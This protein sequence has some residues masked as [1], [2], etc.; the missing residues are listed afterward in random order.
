MRLHRWAIA[1]TTC[2]LA[3]AFAGTPSLAHS[4]D[5]R[6]TLTV[7]KKVVPT[8]DPGKF[9]LRIDGVVHAHNVGNAG[10]TGQVTVV[11]GAHTVSETA[12]TATNL[13]NYVT[14][15]GGD[16]NSAGN[17]T[18]AVGNNKTCI[19]T[20]SRLG[21]LTVVKKVEPPT[22]AGKFNLLIDGHV[23]ADRVGNG[24]TTGAVTV[25]PGAHTVSESAGNGATNLFNYITTYSGDCNATGHV[26]V[27]MG[28]DKLC[29]ITNK[30]RGWT[31]KASMPTAREYFGLGVINN[32]IYVVGGQGD[33]YSALEVY[34]PFTD[35]WVTKASMPTAR[36]GLAVG[37]INGIL[38][39]V[40]GNAPVGVGG[41]H[42]LSTV[43][44]YDPATNTWSTKAPMPTPRDGLAVAV[45]NGILYAIGGD[46]S[47]FGAALNKVEAYDPVTNTWTTKTPL[48]IARAWIS[49]GV[50]ANKI[51]IAGGRTGGNSGPQVSLVQVY[52]PV[53]NAWTNAPPMLSARWGMGVAAA[54]GMLYT[55]GN[56]TRAEAFNPA[57]NSWFISI[58][59]PTGRDFLGLATVNNVLYAIGG[60][61]YSVGDTTKVEAY[62]P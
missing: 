47:V 19:I 39:A 20:N 40:G 61:N 25:Q 62:V 30:L 13:S 43:E 17:V 15:I 8:I 7:V 31:T 29:T 55:V 53:T 33:W 49:A 48:P 54:N 2:A 42:V 21:T 24:G 59:M 56:Y 51:Y 11:P 52:D 50:L 46:V 1:V 14:T 12:G 38:Y 26:N 22:A 10:T 9:N 60:Y 3:A 58:P 35:T 28:E 4:A 37:V 27:A 16:C 34:N 45:V 44:A 5:A 57:T 23:R 36:T 41:V 32:K 6:T 18:L